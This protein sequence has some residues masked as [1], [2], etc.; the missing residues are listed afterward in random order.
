MVLSSAPLNNPVSRN[1]LMIPN[2]QISSPFAAGFPKTS[3]HHAWTRSCPDSSGFL[4]KQK[5]PSDRHNASALL[6]DNDSCD[7]RTSLSS[8]IFT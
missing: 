3:V 1:D 8:T 5:R 4:S 7:G 2:L 6:D